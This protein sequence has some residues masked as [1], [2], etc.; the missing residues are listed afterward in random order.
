M[1]T[2][3]V[4]KRFAASVDARNSA[5]KPSRSRGSHNPI[6]TGFTLRLPTMHAHSTLSLFFNLTMAGAFAARQSPNSNPSY[7]ASATFAI[8]CSRVKLGK[9]GSTR[10]DSLKRFDCEKAARAGI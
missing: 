10:T 7:P 1:T 4:S 5:R 8:C 9:R 3:V 2:R 6:P